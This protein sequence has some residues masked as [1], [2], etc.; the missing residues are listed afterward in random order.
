MLR[1]DYIFKSFKKNPKSTKGKVRGYCAS[2]EYNDIAMTATH[3]ER[4]C[5]SVHRGLVVYDCITIRWTGKITH[6]DGFNYI[7]YAWVGAEDII[8]NTNYLIRFT[9]ANADP[10]IKDYVWTAVHIRMPELEPIILK[11]DN[12][13]II[14]KLKHV[15]NWNTCP[16]KLIL[17]NGIEVSDKHIIYKI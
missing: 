9:R 10:T 1:A 8:I 2:S 4:W 3:M 16:G 14:V 11:R 15:S 6:D 12:Y 5:G 17:A 7:G 13:T